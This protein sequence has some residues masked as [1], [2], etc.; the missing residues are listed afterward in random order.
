MSDRCFYVYILASRKGGALYV[1]VT[2]DLA[3]RVFEHRE[4]KASAF[5]RRYQIHK[6]VWTEPFNDVRD[7][8]ETEK[9]LKR[10]RR[11]W[12]TQLIESQNPG[13]S[14]LYPTLT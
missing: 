10:W 3:R 11:A 13:W 5:T 14:D 6:L 12:K 7:A 9:K 2:N 1:G 4:G 8:I